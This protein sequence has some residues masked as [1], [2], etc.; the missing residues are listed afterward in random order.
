MAVK[1]K[2][3]HYRAFGTVDK[4][5]PVHCRVHKSLRVTPAMGAGIADYVWEVKELLGA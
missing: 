2:V 1:F 4:A 3:A 5:W